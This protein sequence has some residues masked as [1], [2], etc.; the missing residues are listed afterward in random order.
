ML[1]IVGLVVLLYGLVPVAGALIKRYKWFKF[2]HR[3]KGFRLHPII[4]NQTY[5]KME[6]NGE[7]TDI[8]RFIG[9]L[10]SVT[11]QQALWV[12][13]A[14][15][16]VP[17]FLKTA[18]TYLLP[19]QSSGG[20]SDPGDEAPEKINWER[21]ATLSEGTKV[22]VGGRLSYQEGRWGFVSSKESP[23]MVIFYDGPDHSLATKTVWA[24]R[25]GGEYFNPITPY[26]LVLG[27]SCL[28]FIAAFF[29]DRP[30]FRPTVI[31][32]IVAIFLPL[33]PLVPPGLLFTVVYR[34]LTWRS[35]TLRAYSDLAKLPLCYFASKN[36]DI[37]LRGKRILPDGETYGFVR[38]AKL[39][40]EAYDGKIP[41]LIPE[42]TQPS[43]GNW[44]IFGAVLPSDLLPFQPQDPFATFGI[45]PG[46]PKKLAHRCTTKAYAMETIAWIVLLAG[47]ALN[48][49]FL[50]MILSLL[51]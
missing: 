39:P 17:V 46:N 47:I 22:F 4:D 5:W 48:V 13:N 8:F 23:L 7:K 49:F 44:Y 24:G 2:R 34:H 14:G 19:M 9:E 1:V 26:S 33:F 16:L 42:I 15:L 6:A 25:H 50:Q 12:R 36:N 35:R 29:L 45:L 21:V 40:L 30:A 51:L 38:S 10:E 11:D 37:Q 18:E 20:N 31:V 32:S 3:F 27:A 28:L 43:G 41:L